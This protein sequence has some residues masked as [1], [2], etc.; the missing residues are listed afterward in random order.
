M[1]TMSNRDAH[2]GGKIE[3]ETV[4]DERCAGDVVEPIVLDA[5][6]T[7]TS[8][9]PEPAPGQMWDLWNTHRVVAEIDAT[10]AE[11]VV[12]F[13][14]PDHHAVSRTA[15]LAEGQCIGLALPDGRRMLVGETWELDGRRW[16]TLGEVERDPSGAASFC[17]RAGSPPEEWAGWPLS[18]VEALAR[19]SDLWHRVRTVPTPQPSFE[20]GTIWDLRPV[21]K[22]LFGGAFAPGA[23]AEVVRSQDPDGGVLF[24]SGSYMAETS[25]R[26]RGAICVGVETLAGRV[27]VGEQ[28]KKPDGSYFVDAVLGATRVRMLRLGGC[29]ITDF[30]ATDVATWP[31]VDCGDARSSTYVVAAVDAHRADLGLRPI[32]EVLAPHVLAETLADLGRG[33]ISILP[34]SSQMEW[35]SVGEPHIH[36]KGATCSVSCPIN[37][38]ELHYQ[39]W[40]AR[41]A[42]GWSGGASG[43]ASELLVGAVCPSCRRADRVRIEPSACPEVR[44]SV[45]AIGGG[46]LLA[47]GFM[48]SLARDLDRRV[49]EDMVLPPKPPVDERTQRRR[50]IEALLAEDARKHPK[51]AAARRAAVFAAIES[52]GRRPIHDATSVVLLV[53]AV[54]R[55][56][57][58][59]RVPPLGLLVHPDDKVTGLAAVSFFTSARSDKRLPLA[60]PRDRAAAI[61]RVFPRFP[62]Q[63]IAEAYGATVHGDDLVIKGGEPGGSA[64]GIYTIDV[65]IATPVC[66]ADPSSSLRREEPYLAL[67]TKQTHAAENGVYEIRPEGPLVRYRG[68]PR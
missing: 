40:T 43:L 19:P 15:L 6:S 30:S 59:E 34:P 38:P 58:G 47:D 33:G 23:S 27:M 55:E 29:M 41:C 51:H 62:E 28:R 26:K 14:D 20:P 49:A 10:M 60:P 5:T 8:S 12:C 65:V 48:A 31:R 25:L 64:P 1:G 52:A 17:T 21:G 3:A 54:C 16:Y 46:A 35:I 9:K 53:S 56:L 57:D 44:P 22:S 67:L 37:H 11:P 32:S 7:G 66:L 36:P 50:E 39:L 45:E 24:H 18:F 4:L 68:E 61:R 13:I 2:A 42:C 63:T